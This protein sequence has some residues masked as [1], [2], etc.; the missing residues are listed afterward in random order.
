MIHYFID[1]ENVGESAFLGINQISEESVIHVINSNIFHKFTNFPVYTGSS[2][3][4]S[5]T[6]EMA[7]NGE[8]DALDI[9]LGVCLG[10]YIHKDPDATFY[11]LSNDKGYDS[12]IS[13]LQSHGFNV[14]RRM[15]IRG[16]IYEPK[17][18]KETP[19]KKELETIMFDDLG[20]LVRSH[21][22]QDECEDAI[23]E[24]IVEI[25]KKSDK[26]I[27]VYQGIIKIVKG[28]QNALRIYNYIKPMLPNYFKER[29][30]NPE[31]YPEPDKVV[32]DG[33]MLRKYLK[34][35]D[36]PDKLL[37]NISNLA[38]KSKST[39]EVCRG[40]TAML[41]SSKEGSAIYRK[42]KPLLKTMYS[43]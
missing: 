2:K 29:E 17:H 4:I 43:K 36:C 26:L 38:N 14:V 7:Q 11:V 32:V 24:Q 1:F 40:L 9:Q 42:I 39:T 33:E 18:N 25:I 35:E 8:S 23:V 15:N 5:W 3:L 37:G 22:P 10:Y 16:D 34:E 19:S 30:Q 6:F 28:L 20:L 41:N 12:A 13:S 31:K 21:I 27:N